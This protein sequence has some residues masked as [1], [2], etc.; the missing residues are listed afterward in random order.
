MSPLGIGLQAV[1]VNV[2]PLQVRLHEHVDWP[3]PLH[4]TSHPWESIDTDPVVPLGPVVTDAPLSP[5][6][7]SPLGSPSMIT[8]L[9][10][11]RSEIPANAPTRR[12]LMF[13]VSGRL[14]AGAS[15]NQRVSRTSSERW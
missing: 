9:P 2:L 12:C 4:D 7:A 13:A 1:F 15:R 6:P 14:S 10:H 3:A 8:S 5:P 11:A